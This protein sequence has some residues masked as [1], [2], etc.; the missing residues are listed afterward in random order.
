VERTGG[1][2][3][4]FH[5]RP[6]QALGRRLDTAEF[7]DLHGRH[8]GI[9]GEPG[10][11]KSLLL[12]L[13]GG[14]NAAPYFLRAFAYGIISEFFIFNSGNFDEDVDSVEE[15]AA[16]TLLITRD[17]TGGT[18]AIFYRVTEIA[19][20]AGVHGS[21]QHEVGGEGD[22]ALGTADG[23]H[24]V[25]NQTKQGKEA[26]LILKKMVGAYER[27]GVVV[28]LTSRKRKSMHWLKRKFTV[29]GLKTY[30]EKNELTIHRNVKL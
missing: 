5:G 26:V 16:K 6:Q 17:F 19:A 7:P 13:P 30:C 1:K 11:F 9:A 22:T 21:Y 25:L 15:R 18:L 23:D 24:L 27:N 20:G 4:L 14:F 29:S 8:L 3:E 2:V 10:A 28:S 12:N